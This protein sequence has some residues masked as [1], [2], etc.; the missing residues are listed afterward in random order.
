MH[1]VGRAAGGGKHAPRVV[2]MT[3]G[4][5]SHATVVLVGKGV[6]FDTGGL[7][8][9]PAQF[10]R[11][12]KKVQRASPP[13][14]GVARAV[15]RARAGQDMGGSAIILGL[16][17]MVMAAKLKARAPSSHSP[18]SPDG[19]LLLAPPQTRS[20]QRGTGP[21]CTKCSRVA[22]RGLQ[23]HR[24]RRSTSWCCSRRLRTPSRAARSA[25]ATSSPHATA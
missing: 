24:A 7:D 12:M 18:D 25:R 1:A 5:P 2:K 17:H 13:P 19:A 21:R 16:A 3:W 15:T 8:I 6:T 4:D 23:G 10:M 9:K 11:Q 22:P 20:P 14:R